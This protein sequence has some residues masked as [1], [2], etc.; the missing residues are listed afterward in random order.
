[1]P[2]ADLSDDVRLL[3]RLLRDT[4]DAD[5]FPLSP[6]VRRLRAVLEKLEPP[7]PATTPYPPPKPPA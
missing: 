7:R 4:I 5:R 6:R 3:A 2:A 1:M